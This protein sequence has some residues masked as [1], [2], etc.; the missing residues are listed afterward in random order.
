MKKE[1]E[2][3]CPNEIIKNVQEQFCLHA[4]PYVSDNNYDLI[5]LHCNAKHSK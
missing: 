5:F 4:V 1:E 3:A 2:E